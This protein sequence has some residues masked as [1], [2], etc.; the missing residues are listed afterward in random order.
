MK[1]TVILL[2]VISLVIGVLFGFASS[3]EKGTHAITDCSGAQVEIPYEINR[4][5]VTSPAAVAFMTAMGVEDKIVGTHG[6]VLNHFWI[7]VFS[8]HFEG[9]QLFGK[10]P[11]AEELLATDVDL[12]IIKDAAYAADLRKQG[13]TA[14]SFQYTNKDE[15]FFAI[16][17]LGEIFGD[18]AKAYAAAWKEKLDTTIATIESDLA[19]VPETERHSVYYVDSTG[20]EVDLYLTAG[21]GSFVEYWVKSSGGDLITSSYEGLEQIDQETAITLN[22]D[23]ILICGWLEY[24]ARDALMSDPLW[25]ETPAVKNGQVFLMPT[26]CVS[27]DRFAV[28][29]PLMFDYTANLLYPDLHLFGGIDQLREF[30]QQFYSRTFTDEQLEYMLQGLNPDGTKM[31][32]E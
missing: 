28:E 6:S 25:Q 20:A 15:L 9:L 14:V 8:D 11:N 17:M 26:S 2:L 7:Y 22:P 19:G 21:G 13:I 31:V 27:Y 12:V 4:V 10:K 18:N 5:V 23:A 16:D 1:K 24:S 29:L 30:Y 3:E 32:G